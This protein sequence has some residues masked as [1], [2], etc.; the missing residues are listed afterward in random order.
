VFAISFLA[1]L[2]IGASAVRAVVGGVCGFAAAFVLNI[3]IVIRTPD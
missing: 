2:L 1:T 3:S